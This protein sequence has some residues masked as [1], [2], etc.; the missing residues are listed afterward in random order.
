MALHKT[1][2][3]GLVRPRPA[4]GTPLVE[5]HCSQ[6]IVSGALFT[7][8]FSFHKAQYIDH[9]KTDHVFSPKGLLEWIFSVPFLSSQWAKR[10]AEG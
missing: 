7:A 4:P 6:H 2:I 5:E 10:R 1:A 9:L 8:F 3:R